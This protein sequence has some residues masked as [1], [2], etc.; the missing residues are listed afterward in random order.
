V[1]DVVP[2]VSV[3][4]LNPN[5]TVALFSNTGSWVRTYEPGAAVMSTMPRFQGGLEPAA[6]T[7]AYGLEREAIDPDDYESGFALW[8]GTS[9][10]A[11]M[12]AGKLARQ[13]LASMPAAD[14]TEDPADAVARGWDAVHEVVGIARP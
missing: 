2:V 1:R 10:S 14:V 9:F 3:G 11:P 8:S 12:V 6:R 7:E 5:G 4:A 13:M